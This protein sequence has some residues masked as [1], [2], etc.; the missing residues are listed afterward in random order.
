MYY[1]KPW[2]ATS[3]TSLW[4]DVIPC[5]SDIGHPQ[6]RLG[7]NLF[8]SLHDSAVVGG[9]DV[10]HI[11]T[12][13]ESMVC[14]Q[15][16]VVVSRLMSLG[17]VQMD[18]EAFATWGGDLGA[19]AAAMVAC[20]DMSNAERARSEDCGYS[21]NPMALDFYFHQIH[22]PREDLEGDIAPF[23]MRAAES[24][25]ACGRSSMHAY[26]LTSPISS[27]FANF[28]RN[29]GPAGGTS[30]NR[31][32]CFAEAIVHRSTGTKLP[33]ET[34]SFKRMVRGSSLLRRLST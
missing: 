9:V 20:W 15:R 22:A 30:Q 10:G 32:R 13:L 34:N 28:Y 14:P 26:A 11:F 5:S 23:V 4:D 16:Q 24:S 3:Q 19:T 8:Q 17:T 7:K 29:S 12:G 21:V 6:R 31:Y 25:V 33:I 18:N 27:V 2:S 1:G